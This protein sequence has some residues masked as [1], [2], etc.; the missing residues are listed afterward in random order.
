MRHA[1]I[2][3]AQDLC[4]QGLHDP[5]QEIGMKITPVELAFTLL[6]SASTHLYDHRHCGQHGRS[7]SFLCLA[8]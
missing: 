2:V 3:D 4:E 8:M 6:P 7:V 5:V 1:Q